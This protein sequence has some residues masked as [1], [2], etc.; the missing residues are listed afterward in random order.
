MILNGIVFL[1]HWQATLLSV[2][3][4]TL[5]SFGFSLPCVG[6][7]RL[8]LL[9]ITI[10]SSGFLLLLLL[11][12]LILLRKKRQKPCK[13]SLMLTSKD[14]LKIFHVALHIFF[15][16]ALKRFVAS[17]MFCVVFDSNFDFL[18]L[19]SNSSPPQ[20]LFIFFYSVV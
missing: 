9:P 5:V 13:H 18:R 11:A 19:C 14:W 10:Y 8:L 12:R 16:R 20:F 17:K 4:H 1:A 2:Y 7:F 6:F 15:I 3:K